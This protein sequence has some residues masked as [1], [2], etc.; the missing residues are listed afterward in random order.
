MVDISKVVPAIAPIRHCTYLFE[1]TASSR[2]ILLPHA[3]VLVR[4]TSPH[5]RTEKVSVADAQ[6]RYSL[7]LDIDAARHDPVDW[8]MQTDTADG[9]DVEL[10]GR[11]IAMDDDHII[12]VHDGRDSAPAPT[13][14]RPIR[15]TPSTSY[16]EASVG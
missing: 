9:L 8:S 3:R 4:L 14:H 1:G 2:S 16:E 7:V 6:G 15:Y 11:R 13:R 10:A 12:V 5:G